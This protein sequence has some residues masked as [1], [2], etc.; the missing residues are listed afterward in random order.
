MRGSAHRAMINFLATK[1][2][3]KL[4]TTK[5]EEKKNYLVFFFIDLANIIYLHVFFF[6]ERQKLC[7]VL[8]MRS[9]VWEFWVIYMLVRRFIAVYNFYSI[10]KVKRTIHHTNEV[11]CSSHLF[12]AENINN[13]CIA[14]RVLSMLI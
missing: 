13:I 2:K 3:K 14:R 10:R 1:K 8:R 9:R 5:D 6:F 7:F 11:E 4:N 12:L